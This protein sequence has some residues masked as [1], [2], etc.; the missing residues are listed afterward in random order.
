MAVSTE[1]AAALLSSRYPGYT[2]K[3]RLRP[4]FLDVFISRMNMTKG[5]FCIFIDLWALCYLFLMHV[6]RGLS[7][8]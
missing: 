1:C 8:P 6:E 2:F 4:Q 5:L 3:V 7:L